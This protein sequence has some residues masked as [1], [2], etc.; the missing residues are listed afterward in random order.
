MA[1]ELEQSHSGTAS[2]EH[3]QTPR[4]TIQRKYVEAG[5]HDIDNDSDQ[6]DNEW[7]RIV[8]GYAHHQLDTR[9]PKVS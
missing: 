8:I 6:G 1:W 5:D 3:T 7:G 2:P 9:Q 4:L